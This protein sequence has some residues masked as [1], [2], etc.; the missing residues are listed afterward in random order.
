M[1]WASEGSQNKTCLEEIYYLNI[2]VW[3]KNIPLFIFRLRK[4][5][6]LRVLGYMWYTHARVQVYAHECTQRPDQASSSTAF[7]LNALS[8]DGHV[9]K[10]QLTF[11]A[12]MACQGALRTLLSLA[13]QRWGS[14]Y[15]VT[16]HFLYGSQRF[17]LKPLHLHGNHS[18]NHHPRPQNQQLLFKFWSLRV[19]SETTEFLK[20]FQCII[21]KA[22]IQIEIC[23]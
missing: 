23:M 5:K 11:R 6:P 2:G 13:P 18:L 19:L 22:G 20:N 7:H 12:R 8:W 9:R 4:R 16:P 10:R 15:A 14:M 21:F 1:Q 3:R 17:K